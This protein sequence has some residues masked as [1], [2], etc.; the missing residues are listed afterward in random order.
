MKPKAWAAQPL[1]GLSGIKCGENFTNPSHMFG[2]SNLRSSSSYRRLNP[3]CLK[4]SIIAP[5]FCCH[6]CKSS[7]YMCQEFLYTLSLHLALASELLTC[8]KK[9]RSR[10]VSERRC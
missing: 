10:L 7:I 4:L 2:G 1:N 9:A 3:L 8:G 6:Q 5:R